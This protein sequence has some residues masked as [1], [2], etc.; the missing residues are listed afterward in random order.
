MH[1]FS[2]DCISHLD[3]LTMFFKQVAGE[4]KDDLGAD[5]LFSLFEPVLVIIQKEVQK[6]TVLIPPTRILD[7]IEVF[8]KIPD[9]AVV[10][11]Q[12]ERNLKIIFV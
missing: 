4:I 3:E 8:S 10:R 11:V 5:G 2:E 6:G 1:V 9:F 7:V 12:N